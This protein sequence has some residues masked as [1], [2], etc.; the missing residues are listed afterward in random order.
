MRALSRQWWREGRTLG[1]VPTMGNLHEGHLSLM[2]SAVA[3][4]DEA[5]ASIYVNPLQFGAG[6]DFDGYPRTWEAD[7]A[8]L[9]EA[10]V[11]TVFAP[12]DAVMY[13]PGFATSVEVAGLTDGLCARSRPGHFRGVTTVVMKLLCVVLPHR[14]YFG[15]KDYQQ[16]AVIRRMT[17]DLGLGVQIVPM[18][19]WREP[20]GLAMSS[21]NGYLSDDERARAVVLSRAIAAAQSVAAETDQAAAILAAANEV[22]AAEPLA[23]VDYV[24][25]VDA[26]TLEP[27]ERVERP[28][29]LCLAVHIGPAR[30]IDNGP[31]LP[32][33]SPLPLGEG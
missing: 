33:G 27:L 24:E 20:S 31:V 22:L 3:E 21:R 29:R 1:L 11:A 4:C 17:D 28:A 12:T 16:L 32:P 7:L 15:E 14:A 25:L 9:A 5:V 13:P 30:L 23:R 18:P 2:R 19:T 10:G 6:E 26:E 8:T